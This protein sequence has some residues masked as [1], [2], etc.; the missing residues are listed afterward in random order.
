MRMLG[1]TPTPEEL[2]EMIDEVD[3]DGTSLCYSQ[4]VPIN[5]S[6]MIV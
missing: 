1:Q 5:M 3:E 4:N 2:Q 6:T